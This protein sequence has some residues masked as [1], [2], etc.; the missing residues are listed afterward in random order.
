MR[1]SVPTVA[2]GRCVLAGPVRI[3]AWPDDSGLVEALMCS[4]TPRLVLVEP[5]C[6]PPGGG[7]CC[8][9]W[10]WRNGTEDEMRI[11]IRQLSLRAVVHG[12]VKPYIDDLGL[13]HVGLRWVRLAPKEQALAAALLKRFNAVVPVDD[14]IRAA[15][16]EGIR[17][18]NV[19]A[20]RMSALRARIAWVG[21]EISGTSGKGYLM[22]VNTSAAG[23]EE[24]TGF[25]DEL[26]SVALLA[27]R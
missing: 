10:M 14:L 13:L 11:R 22:A 21:L 12:H 19:L 3:I 16:P 18:P 5:G 23:S 20:V 1:P 15:W 4:P 8:Q 17:R 26:E 24:L 9:D 6:E 2:P 25:E 7:D 27:S